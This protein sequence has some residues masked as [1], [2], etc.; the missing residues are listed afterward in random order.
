MIFRLQDGL[1]K[2][3]DVCSCKCKDLDECTCPRKQKVPS[4]E[5]D[6]RNERKMLMEGVDENE[7]RRLNKRK[8]R[9]E[10]SQKLESEMK[11]KNNKIEA[12]SSRKQKSESDQ[13]SKISNTS[14]RNMVKLK[15]TSEIAD[16]Y[17]VSNYAVAQIATAALV[18]Y[19]IITENHQIN[20]IDRK[21]LQRA[22]KVS[23][24]E[25]IDTHL[26]RKVDLNA[27]F[28]IVALTL[29]KVTLTVQSKQK[30]K[31]IIHLLKNLAHTFLAFSPQRNLKKMIKSRKQKLPEIKSLSSVIKTAFRLNFLPQ[32]EVMELH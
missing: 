29:Q 13:Q 20:V 15:R 23:R 5:K 19:N 12:K 25:N 22:R 4:I 26:N 3:F 16:R 6:Q 2:L 9:N 28:S 14:Q 31:I 17:G 27:I 32:L 1:R 18:D 8:S 7:T 21:K 11:L 24:Q 30:K 10:K